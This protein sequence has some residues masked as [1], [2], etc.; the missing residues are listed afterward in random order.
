MAPSMTWKASSSAP[1]GAFMAWFIYLSRHLFCLSFN[2]VTYLLTYLF[3]ILIFYSRA[4]ARSRT[5][6]WIHCNLHLCTRICTHTQVHAYMLTHLYTW[7]HT[8]FQTCNIYTPSSKHASYLHKFIST[9]IHNNI[10]AYIWNAPHM[11]TFSLTPAHTSLWR[12]PVLRTEG[13]KKRR[14][15]C[16]A[17]PPIYLFSI[18]SLDAVSDLSLWPSR[19]P[20]WFKPSCQPAISLLSTFTIIHERF[21]CSTPVHSTSRTPDWLVA[22]SRRSCHVPRRTRNQA[23]S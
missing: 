13:N 23:N 9:C 20:H 10:H 15:F 8:N 19:H 6:T 2:V 14:E 16:I 11:Y 22:D 3:P 21:F 5:Y 7:I 18:Y 12:R 1:S 17:N 4:V